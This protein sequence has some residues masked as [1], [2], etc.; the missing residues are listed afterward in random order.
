ML[1]AISILAMLLPFSAALLK[2]AK[3]DHSYEEL[4]IQQFFV[5]LRDELIQAHDV[6]IAAHAI[7]FTAYLNGQEER[8][9]IELYQDLARRR[10]SSRGHEIFLRNIDNLFFRKTE[11]GLQVIVKSAGGKQYEKL[12][13]LY[14]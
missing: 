7:Y 11:S 9:S 2:A 4:A 10:V 13:V 5:H 1:F 14:P 12:M 8:T 3:Y 6:K